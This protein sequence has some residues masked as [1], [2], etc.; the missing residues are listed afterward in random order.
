MAKKPTNYI[1]NLSTK[2][3]HRVKSV[4]PQCNLGQI[5]E[6]VDFTRA[7]DA[8]KQGYDACAHCN[9]HWKSKK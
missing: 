9:H 8:F 7:R 6:R 1:G 2:E 3:L 5:K 4:E